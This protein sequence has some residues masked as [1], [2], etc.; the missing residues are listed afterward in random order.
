MKTIK[1]YNE[2]NRFIIDWT[3]N[4]LCTYHC[5]YCPPR[6]HTGTNVFKSKQEDPVIIKEFLTKIQKE[7]IGRSVHVFVNGGEPTISPSLETIS[8]GISLA[9]TA[10]CIFNIW[11]TDEDKDNGFINMGVAKN[12]FG[13]NFG[14]TVLKI[15]YTTLTLSEEDVRSGT[16][17]VCEF[18]KS[19]KSLED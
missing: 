12:R 7:V 5:S 6:L 9:N 2:T 3:L 8:E 14:S 17:E 19:I 11:Q 18:N 4:T 13:P 15:D 10:D 1:I 16:D